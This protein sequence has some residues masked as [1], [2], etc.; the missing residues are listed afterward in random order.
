MQ[1]WAKKKDHLTNKLDDDESN[2]MPSIY[3]ERKNIQLNVWK[4]ACV[5]LC[6]SSKS[7][8]TELSIPN[9]I[10]TAVC[11]INSWNLNVIKVWKF[12]QIISSIEHS[13]STKMIRL[14]CNEL[15]VSGSITHAYTIQ[16]ESGEKKTEKEVSIAHAPLRCENKDGIEWGRHIKKRK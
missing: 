4:L 9:T 3:I 11:P 15:H 8:T 5:S 16:W 14:N 12:T 13:K 6:C 2:W 1:H 10:T 7:W